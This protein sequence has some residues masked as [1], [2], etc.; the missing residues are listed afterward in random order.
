MICY[1][2]YITVSDSTPSRSGLYVTNLPGVEVNLLE[3]LKTSDQADYLAL[4]KMVYKRAWDNL[5]SDISNLLAD[6]FFVD[7]KLLARET[8]EFTTTV[9]SGSALAGIRISFDLP[10]YARI[11]IISAEVFSEAD[12]DSPDFELQFFRDNESGEL[13]HTASGE[14]SQGRSVLN[15]DT[16]F[17]VCDL[18][19]GY[20][21]SLYSVR[22]TENK[23]FPFNWIHWDKFECAFPCQWGKGGVKQINGGGLNIKYVV[24]CSVEKFVC[25]NINLFK[26]AFL[27][28]IG[29]EILIERRYGNT[30][31][32]FTAMKAERAE[33]LTEFYVNTYNDK[34]AN[35]IK[36]HNITE[37]P[38]CF[39]CKSSVTQKTILP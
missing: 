22:K 3:D 2:D 31:N 27:W 18:F 23:Y 15:V 1:A 7:L 24:Y 17:E 8:S 28:R 37:D 32:C 5:V 33:E 20:D 25:E 10:K 26:Q 34:L 29:N 11:H 9:N 6:K 13:L 39:N 35:G 12:Y 21:P 38:F 16:D 30:V 4:W 14:V 19:I 36:G